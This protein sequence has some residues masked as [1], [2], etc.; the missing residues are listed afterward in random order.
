MLIMIIGGQGE[1]KL[2]YCKKN[3]EFDRLSVIEDLHIHLREMFL[4]D[5]NAFIDKLAS[6]DIIIADE[7]GYG[8]VPIEKEQ[9]Q[10]RD[11]YGSICTELAKRADRVI[12]IVCGIEQLIKG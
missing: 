6:K 3:F 12:R 9:R 10:F 7:I 4:K 11:Y 2:G 8:I 5:E 1:D